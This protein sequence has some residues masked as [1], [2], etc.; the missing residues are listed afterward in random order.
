[1]I[2]SSSRLVFKLTIVVGIAVLIPGNNGSVDPKV[3]GRVDKRFALTYQAQADQPP[4]K[5][6]L[7]EL[8]R[9]RRQ[10]Y[11][12][13]HHFR[14]V[15]GET[16]PYPGQYGHVQSQA[17]YPQRQELRGGWPRQ[18]RMARAVDQRGDARH[19]PS[20]LE[21]PRKEQPDNKPDEV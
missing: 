21:D 14:P 18:P 2:S 6:P 17:G 16:N 15:G 19:P 8:P 13:P 5:H 4:H 12:D 10:T 7:P 1:M 11:G 9:A 3:A 20:G